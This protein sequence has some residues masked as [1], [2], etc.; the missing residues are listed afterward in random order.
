MSDTELHIKLTGY[1]F[2]WQV[3][4]QYITAVTY[5]SQGSQKPQEGSMVAMYT[6]G[7]PQSY[8]T[9]LQ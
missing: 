6:T 4:E 5:K 7:I 9:K 8:N 3:T 2:E 1:I